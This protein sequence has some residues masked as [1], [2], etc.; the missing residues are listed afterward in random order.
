MSESKRGSNGG[1]ARAEK[2]TKEQRSTIAKQAAA[3]R[4]GK[5]KEE[6]V[7]IDTE[8]QDGIDRNREEIGRSNSIIDAMKEK[9]KSI[10]G[11]TSPIP[12]IYKEEPKTQPITTVDSI[13]S[14]PQTLR[15]TPAEKGRKRASK[16]NQT[17]S[18]VYRQA[19]S[20]AEKE[21]EETAEKL[22]YHDEMAA[23]LK[24]RM[25]RLIQTIK[26]LGGTI[27]PQV[28]MQSYPTQSFNTPMQDFTDPARMN[29]PYQPIP[30]IEQNPIDP[31]LYRTNSNPLPGLV[32]AAQN[33]PM[34]PN[35]SVGGAIDLDYSP[36]E[37]EGPKLANMGGGWV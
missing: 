20:T 10:S 32:P 4:W 13:P 17:V 26:A 34:V 21:Y 16:E 12:F 14:S 7:L 29:Q 3:K 25:P 24:A 27:D 22:A 37:D 30:A 33:A 23:R 6:I 19:L 31:A 1:N 5:Q 36:V 11:S 18:K 35:T 8:T 9:V 28:A 2:L 15:V